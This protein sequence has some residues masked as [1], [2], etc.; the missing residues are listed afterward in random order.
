ML[1]LPTGCESR[2]VLLEGRASMEGIADPRM[3]RVVALVRKWLLMSRDP[4]S[5]RWRHRRQGAIAAS[6]F[7]SADPETR[8][9]WLAAYVVARVREGFPET[10][11]VTDAQ[12]L[13]AGSREVAERA[14]IIITTTDEIEAST[15]VQADQVLMRVLR[16]FDDPG[17]N[18]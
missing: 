11:T 2:A 12:A 13:A 8:A 15:R 9:T 14:R 10:E 6:A 16:L 5:R 4:A 7:G 18:G 17:L 3:A 1:S